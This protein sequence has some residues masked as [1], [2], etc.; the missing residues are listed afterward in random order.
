MR[1]L[2]VEPAGVETDSLAYQRH[3]RMIRGS[4]AQVDQPGRLRPCPAHGVNHV[5]PGAGQCIANDLFEAGAMSF[6][7]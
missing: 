7:Q 1:I 6:R 3:A 2:D 4:P 5:Q